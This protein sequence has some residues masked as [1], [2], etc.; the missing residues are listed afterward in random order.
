MSD[1]KPNIC[2]PSFEPLPAV[3]LMLER[4]PRLRSPEE[5]ASYGEASP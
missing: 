2:E 3:E 5:G 1:R 4:H